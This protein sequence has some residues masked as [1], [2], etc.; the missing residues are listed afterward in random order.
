MPIFTYNA[1]SG[2]AKM[3]AG[4]IEAVSEGEALNKLEEMG[5]VPVRILEKN[6]AP[7]S[8][9]KE[10]S[11][12]ESSD[13]WGHIPINRDNR[14][15]SPIK[16]IKRMIKAR[17]RDI[18][19]FTRQLA[20][21]VKSSVPML[22][23][24][25]LLARQ[26][27]NKALKDVVSGLGARIK[28]GSMLSEAMAAYPGVF[29]NFYL[30]MVKSGERSGTLDAALFRL[31]EHREREQELKYRIQAALAYPVLVASV[32]AATIFVMLTYFLPK[33]TLIFKGMKQELPLPTKILMGVTGFMSAYWYI[34]LI[35]AVCAAIVIGRMR[36]GAGKKILFDAFILKLP[37]LKRFTR[38]AEIAKF[39]RSLGILLKSGLP[40]H[41]SLE[42]AADTLDNEAMKASIAQ[43]GR[44]IV[45][46]GLSL[47]ESFTRTRIFPDFTINMISVGEQGG[48]V[49]EALEEIANVYEREVDQSIKIMSSLLEPLL[50]LTVGAI[51]GFIVFAMLLPV[52]N[53]G[54]MGK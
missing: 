51:V 50:I 46:Q 33:L 52:F 19:T 49:T 1:K 38:N 24:M 11:A 30:S 37:F 48:K 6:T 53:I 40:V 27:E 39:A 54:V 45:E 47:S 42:L 9:K 28:D 8:P 15:V 35:A 2:P 16:I 22:Q 4:E 41:E 18:D 7:A 13:N 10:A 25:A 32:G 31:A 20:S 12:E 34:F 17:S 43:A 44:G 26:T 14:D 21:L 29:N 36:S 23:T 5:L 3:V